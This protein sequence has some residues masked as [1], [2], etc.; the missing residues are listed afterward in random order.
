MPVTSEPVVLWLGLA[1]LLAGC[2][3]PTLRLAPP[4][5][6]AEAVSL[7]GDTLWSVTLSAA[8]GQARVSQLAEAK[9]RAGAR[10]DDLN[11]RLLLG[12]RTAAMGRLR[13]AIDIYTE[14]IEADPTDPR[15]F[16][17]RGELL[18]LVREP[19][20]AA[21]DLERA[22]SRARERISP[23][24][25][26][27][28]P[29]VMEFL[30]GPDGQLSGAGVLHS[31]QLLLGMTHFIR[32]DYR[33]AYP[34]LVAAAQ[35]ADDADG[36]ATASLWLLFTLRRAG[37]LAEAGQIAKVIPADLPVVH[38]TAELR[39]LQAFAGTLSLDSL[40]R[41]LGGDIQSE[42]AG[43]YLY[44]LGSTL[45]ARGR[46]AEAAEALDEVRHTTNWASIIYV[47]AE[48]DLA[49]LRRPCL[50]PNPVRFPD[51]RWNRCLVTAIQ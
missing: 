35:S 8:E 43:L 41:G 47:A 38:R 24:G 44:G 7:L 42:A 5:L 31:S 2:G 6:G 28:A 45:L 33:R 29:P 21:R 50:E 32:G 1:G 48:A 12:R 19:D 9:R 22:A 46:Q 49:R 20:L 27:F 15:L 18:L 3:P 30:E 11:T 51:H 23:D 40:Q 26:R 39:L 13:E 16:R 25:R 37:R 36:I 4:P 10:W 17:R 14:A 34:M